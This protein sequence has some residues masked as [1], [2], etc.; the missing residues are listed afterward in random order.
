[1]REME[2]RIISTIKNG[3]LKASEGD[4]KD[5]K[6]NDDQNEPKNG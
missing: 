3:Q 2:D 6:K 5:V 1:M 4:K